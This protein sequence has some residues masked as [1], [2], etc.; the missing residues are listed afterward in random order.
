MYLVTF[1]HS[2]RLFRCVVGIFACVC[3]CWTEAPKCNKLEIRLQ[4]QTQ[5]KQISQSTLP[6]HYCSSSWGLCYRSC[7]GCLAGVRLKTLQPLYVE[8]QNSTL[9]LMNT[10]IKKNKKHNSHRE[11]E[12]KNRCDL[13][14][15]CQKAFREERAF[16]TRLAVWL[17][18]SEWRCC[19]SEAPHI[20]AVAPLHLS[21]RNGVEGIGGWRSVFLCC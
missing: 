20:S 16:M 10:L 3:L 1:H 19:P 13:G 17:R 11:K 4:Q 21:G 2:K 7:F 8:V 12:T 18:T 14:G 9:R 5:Y 15:V 6:V